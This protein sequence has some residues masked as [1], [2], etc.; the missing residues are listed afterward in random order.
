[1]NWPGGDAA[2][3]VETNI[4]SRI[5]APSEKGAG[6]MFP[7]CRRVDVTNCCDVNVGRIVSVGDFCFVEVWWIRVW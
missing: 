6:L 3:F 1:M 4:T 5:P 2:T 7:G